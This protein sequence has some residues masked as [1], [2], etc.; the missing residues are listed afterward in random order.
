MSVSSI[1]RKPEGG[2]EHSANRR[3]VVESS[4]YYATVFSVHTPPPCTI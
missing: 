2:R 4:E 1:W 3:R